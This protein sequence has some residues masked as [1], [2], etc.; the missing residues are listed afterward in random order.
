MKNADKILS[1]LNAPGF[2]DR[3]LEQNETAV[4]YYND[5][6]GFD[7]LKES[8]KNL[9]SMTPAQIFDMCEDFFTFERVKL[10]IAKERECA[11]ANPLYASSFQPVE[12]SFFSGLV[13]VATDQFTAI[14]MSMDGYE[15]ELAKQRR[16]GQKRSLTFAGLP[17]SLHFYQAH[18]VELATWRIPPFVDEDDLARSDI[19][20]ER[21]GSATYGTGDRAVFG[22]FETFEY[23]SKAGS[24]ALCLQ[25]QMHQ[26]GA[27][28]SLQF[29]IDTLKLIGASSP[30]QEP[31]RLQMLATAM[32][33]FGRT[34][35][36]EE[37]ESLLSHPSHYVRWHAMREC[38]GMDAA[39]AH[40]R[41]VHMS[42]QDPQPA[43]RRAA[44][45]TLKQ[46][47]PPE[48]VAA[49]A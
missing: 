7:Q 15:I 46:F 33:M 43:V 36:M 48:L 28:M 29:D 40:P 17:A 25:V 8:M 34:D 26:G 2:N 31:T 5:V 47:F 14:L 37:M 49:A 21:V 11:E 39:W 1:L 35:A 27:P 4:R 42:E 44:S 24:S 38:I 19:R 16:P 45:A 30:S 12:G 13:L 32:R 23:N 41:L 9:R 20:P 3:L 18:R 10:I 22:N 6:L